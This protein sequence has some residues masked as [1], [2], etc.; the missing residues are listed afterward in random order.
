MGFKMK[1]I[2]IKLDDVWKIYRIGEVKVPALRGLNLKIK[3]GEFVAVQ[4]ASGSGKSTALNSIGCLDVPTKGKIYLEGKDI[5]NKEILLDIA[6]KLGFKRADALE[7]ISSPEIKE[8]L[9]QEVNEGIEAKVFGAP[10]FIVDGEKF[11]GFDRLD[12]LD[13]WLET[14]GW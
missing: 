10:F 13:K 3:R 6:E 9:K 5:S 7:G 2:I 11:W 1:D 14:G 12:Q 4:G 8:K